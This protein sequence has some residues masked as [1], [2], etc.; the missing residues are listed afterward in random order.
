MAYVSLSFEITEFCLSA[1]LFAGTRVQ[2][3]A[4]SG[5][6][7]W[8]S[9][10]M[11]FCCRRLEFGSQYKVQVLITLVLTQYRLL[12]SG[13]CTQLAQLYKQVILNGGGWLERRLRG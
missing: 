7:R 2:T 1:K 10:T 11:A 8:L 4:G 12:A 9:A 13:H 5:L 3:I 6:E